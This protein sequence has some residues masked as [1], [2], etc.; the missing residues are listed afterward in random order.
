VAFCSPA[1]R[2]KEL[3]VMDFDG[4]NVVPMTHDRSIA[5]SPAFS[6]DGSLVLFTSYR[7]G[8]GPQIYVMPVRGGHPYLVSGGPGITPSSSYSPDGREIVCTLSYEGNPEVYV[9]DARGGSPH[10]LTNNRGIDTS[11]AWSPTGRE[12]AFTSDRSGTFNVY[13]MDREGGNV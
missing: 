3:Y 11:P 12:I 6:S 2:E 9:L 5:L 13:V 10:R 7:G 8:G 1:G 4:E